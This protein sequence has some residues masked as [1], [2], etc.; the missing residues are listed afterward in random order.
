MKVA[1]NSIGEHLVTFASNGVNKGEPVKV[2]AAG[3]V[4]P[5]SAGDV[6]DGAAVDVRGGYA[7][8]ALD[9]FVTLPYTGTAPGIGHVTL[10]ADG[11]GGVKTAASGGRTVLAVDVDT[12]AKTVCFK[13]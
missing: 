1:F 10:A 5:C 8:V 13:L 7:S 12:A 6:F 9:G 11:S 3:T 2:S 4:S